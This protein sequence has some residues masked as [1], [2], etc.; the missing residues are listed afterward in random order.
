MNEFLPD[1]I[2]PPGVTI[3]NVLVEQSLSL[4]DLASR[5][6]LTLDAT[7]SLIDGQLP[8]TI[9]LA[10]KLEI[11][12][13]GSLE[14]WISRDHQYREDVARIY[15]EDKEWVDQL[16]IAEMM[17]FGWIPT[18]SDQG[19]R[20]KSILSFFGLDT[21]REVRMHYSWKIESANYKRSS[22]IKGN[23][24]ALST[25]LRRGEIESHRATVESNWEPEKFRATLAEIRNLTRSKSV[26]Q[27]FPSLVRICAQHGLALVI[28][29]A[30]TGTGVSGAAFYRPDGTP[31]IMMSLR[32][33]TNDHFWFTFFHEVA[34]VLEGTQR[35]FLDDDIAAG[36]FEAN[37]FAEEL[38]IPINFRE[39]FLNLKIDKKEIIKFAHKIGTAPGI[40]VGQLQYYKHIRQNHFNGLKRRLNWEELSYET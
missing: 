19:L 23:S 15:G 4:D 35:T 7:N 33:G 32:F 37:R 16:P 17:D 10:K 11:T 6:G 2:S 14:F 40:V 31:V 29:R 36:E 3:Q 22:K 12:L 27:F 30:P 20:L 25:W 9:G 26:S 13:G 38:L 24:V 18:S 28:L 34:H 5:L 39:E 8:I 21:I 1:W